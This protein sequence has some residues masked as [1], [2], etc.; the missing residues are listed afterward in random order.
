MNSEQL[1]N[2][3]YAAEDEGKEVFV[4]VNKGY[5]VINNIEI[6]GEQFINESYE[7]ELSDAYWLEDSYQ[8]A[9][10]STW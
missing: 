4:N 5:D 7:D 2:M 9:E 1:R 8:T 3:W 6:D 10:R